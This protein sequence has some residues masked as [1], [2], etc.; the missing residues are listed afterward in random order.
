M[1]FKCRSC[2][3]LAELVKQANSTPDLTHSSSSSVVNFTAAPVPEV[4][5]CYA[6]P[7]EGVEE[8]RNVAE[9][10][11]LEE[12]TRRLHIAATVAKNRTV[13][14][15][16]V[17]TP[18]AISASQ[19]TAPALELLTAEVSEAM[20]AARRRRKHAAKRAML[21]MMRSS[22]WLLEKVPIA[23]AAAAAHQDTAVAS[24]G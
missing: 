13:L 14:A 17:T 24:S 15:P 4:A 2:P 10:L 11:A 22:K 1:A 5:A 8:V 18:E 16:R 7:Y 3:N 6:T 20:D 23:A 9:E 19:R 21:N 12:A